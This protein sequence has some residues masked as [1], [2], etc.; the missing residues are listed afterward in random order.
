MTSRAA[1]APQVGFNQPR[2]KKHAMNASRASTPRR[3]NPNCAKCANAVSTR[4][5]KGRTKARRAETARA[6]GTANLRAA[7][8]RRIARNALPECGRAYSRRIAPSRARPA[9]REDSRMRRGCSKTL[10]RA[11]R[12]RRASLARALRRTRM[13]PRALNA[14][15]DS[16]SATAEARSA[17]PACQG[18]RKQE[19][20]ASSARAVKRGSF[21]PLRMRPAACTARRAPFRTPAVPRSV[22]NVCPACFRARLGHTSVLNAKLVGTSRVSATLRA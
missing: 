8:A 11:N 5:T 7:R 9:R 18:W 4:P 21:N 19:R 2:A 3:L 22:E 15:A 20:R 1:P 13:I 16:T 17:F 12:A 6:E 14:R 10:V